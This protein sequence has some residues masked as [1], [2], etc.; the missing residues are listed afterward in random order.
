MS[1]DL[2]REEILEKLRFGE[3]EMA[4]ACKLLDELP[5]PLPDAERIMTEFWPWYRSEKL[6][7]EVEQERIDSLF[8]KGKITNQEHCKLQSEL[9]SAFDCDADK[10][11]WSNFCIWLHRLLLK[12]I[13][14]RKLEEEWKLEE[15]EIKQRKLEEE[16]GKQ[17]LEKSKLL[18]K[19]ASGELEKDVA[20]KLLFELEKLPPHIEEYANK[21]RRRK[22][23]EENKQQRLNKEK[24]QERLKQW[25]LEKE[26]SGKKGR[27][28]IGIIL[29]IFSIVGLYFVVTKKHGPDFWEQNDI[30]MLHFEEQGRPG[31]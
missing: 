28:V 25:M 23:K 16:I 12:P 2:T 24:A 3:L 11:S 30:D 10:E 19:L 29:L 4:A 17:E 1:I 20:S 6:C 8:A 22:K 18:K 5:Q 14:Q 13:E 26:E 9:R 31:K 15:E 7:H 21:L 27:A